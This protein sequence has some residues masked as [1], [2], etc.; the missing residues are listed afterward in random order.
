MENNINYG[1]TKDL[2]ADIRYE[3]NA[4]KLWVMDLSLGCPMQCIYC[5]FSPLELM[6]YKLQNPGYKGE[7]LPL[8]LDNFLRREEFPPVVYLSYSSD[9]LGNDQLIDN[10][11]IVLERLFQRNIHVLLLT[12]GLFNQKLLEMVKKRPDLMEIQVGITNHQTKR[13][14]IIEP[15]APTYS[16]R[17]E[18]L[19]KLSAIEG[20]RSL[21]VRLDPL[22]PGIDDTLENVEKIVSDASK[23]GVKRAVMSYLVLPRSMME[24]VKQ[25]DYL[26][27]SVEKLTQQTP[28]ISEK[29]LFS[30]PLEKKLETFT[31][32][33]AL[34]R[35]Y[36]M[37]M[38]VCGCK[39]HRFRET[40]TSFGR[41]CFP[42]FTI[43]KREELS[44]DF[45]IKLETSHLLCADSD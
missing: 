36:G 6:I 43:Q 30:Y 35:R 17:M 14:E 25:E 22:F 12:K 19:E 37:D 32:M 39:E 33:E 1:I 23:L 13:N 5:L 31:Q 7:I 18:N 40:K 44:S 16:Q 38:A 9:P 27:P 24:K 29:E 45:S 4:C 3:P 26:R 21:V 20:L 2:Q 42:F 11:I 28:T 34:C 8:K 10:T 15:G 41:T